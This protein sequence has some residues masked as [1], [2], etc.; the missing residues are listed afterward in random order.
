MFWDLPNHPQGQLSE[1]ADLS[2]P[3]KRNLALRVIGEVLKKT[4]IP[5]L[6]DELNL[7]FLGDVGADALIMKILPAIVDLVVDAAKGK[8]AINRD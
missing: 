6:P 1:L 2:G 7:P 4:D 3:E 8:L 5:F